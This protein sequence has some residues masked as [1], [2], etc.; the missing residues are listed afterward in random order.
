[1]LLHGIACDELC[2]A[3]GG[4]LPVDAA[5]AVGLQALDVLRSAHLAGIV[6]RDIKPA[7]L[8]LLRTGEIKVLDFGIARVRETLATGPHSTGS[9]VLLGT[10]A[11]MAPEQAMCKASYVYARADIWAIGATLFA[12]MTGVTVHQGDSG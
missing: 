8:F 12:M 6:H 5:C 7:N 10:P 3:R 2:S 4:R 1:E 9:G 11:F